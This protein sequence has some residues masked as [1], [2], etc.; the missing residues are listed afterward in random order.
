MNIKELRQILSEEVTK[1]VTKVFRT[2]IRSILVE[3]MEDQGVSESSEL[4]R[5]E[6]LSPTRKLSDVL[7]ETRNTMNRDDYRNFLGD[8]SPVS[9]KPTAP[10]LEEKKIVMNGMPDFLVR[11]VSQAKDV[12]DLANQKD[13]DKN[14]L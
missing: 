11:A 6:S 9:F 13:R 7:Q 3:I 2:E 1:A 10:V 4:S 14:V 8:S 5:E 12:L